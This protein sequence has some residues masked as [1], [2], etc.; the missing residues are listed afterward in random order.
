[1]NFLIH[2]YLVTLPLGLML[3]GFLFTLACDLFGKPKWAAWVSFG[4]MVATM[5]VFLTSGVETSDIL[6]GDIYKTI[7]CDDF[8]Y[9]YCGIA[10]FAGCIAIAMSI[11][12]TRNLAF[13]LP[14]EFFYLIFPF[15]IGLFVLSSAR[16]ALVFYLAL[17]MVSVLSYIMVSLQKKPLQHEASFRYLSTGVASSAVMI[18]GMSWLVM[19]TGSLQLDDWFWNNEE[20][21]QTLLSYVPLL[22]FLAGLLFKVTAFPLHIW[23]PDVYEAGPTPVIALLSVAPKVVAAGFLAGYLHSTP[24]MVGIVIITILIGNL[25][26]I[27]QQ[28]AKRLMAYSSI[29]QAA[30]LLIPSIVSGESR[31]QVFLLYASV[32]APMKLAFFVGIYPVEQQ[33]KFVNYDSFQGLGKKYPLYFGLFTLAAVSLIGLPPTG[34]FTAKLIL[35]TY[36]IGQ[37]F[38]G[39]FSWI[40]YIA[41]W[42]AVASIGVSIYYYLAVPFRVWFRQKNEHA[43]LKISASD[44]VLM[45]ILSILFVLPFINP[46]WIIAR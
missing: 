40:Y 28:N 13:K 3:A 9:K 22:F 38:T 1:M 27:F 19:Q 42:V 45:L 8:N 41:M 37:P 12:Q 30:F 17:E 25:G 21:S 43:D 7:F 26:A 39:D 31:E 16:H 29:A 4:F 46:S 23:A 14:P 44:Y 32:Y 10:V 35:F 36:L 34:G 15:F 2:N 6:Y 11:F 24:I 5:G 33:F 20:N 18:M